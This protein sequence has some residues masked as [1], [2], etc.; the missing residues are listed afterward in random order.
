MPR[1]IEVTRPDLPEKVIGYRFDG[2]RENGSIGAYGAPESDVAPRIG[3]RPRVAVRTWTPHAF[4][5]RE[6]MFPTYC[7]V[8]PYRG[9][10]CG[11][12]VT[13]DIHELAEYTHTGPGMSVTRTDTTP[14]HQ[15][16]VIV[17]V[18]A[19]GPKMGVGRSD[20]RSTFRT[21]WASMNGRCWIHEDVPQ[22]TVRL[23]LH[24]WPFLKIERFGDLSEVPAMVERVSGKNPQPRSQRREWSQTRTSWDNGDRSRPLA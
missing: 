18:T 11:W 1:H 12:F 21:T 13:P 8:A 10:K 2:I 15:R 7:H 5:C 9:C 22:R 16:P 19:H 3:E 17:E 4:C 24:H 6:T 23:A 20:P 14:I